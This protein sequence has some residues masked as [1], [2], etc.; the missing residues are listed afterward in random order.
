MSKRTEVLPGTV[1]EHMPSS[2]GTQPK[3]DG[4]EV[5]LTGVRIA[6]G[7]ARGSAWVVGDRLECRGDAHPINPHEVE[8]EWSRIRVAFDQTRAELQ[9]AARRVAE[10]FTAPLADI[11]RAHEMMLDSLLSSPEFSQE[12]QG[13]RVH[14]ETA[15]R[16][17]F[18]RWQEKFRS[19]N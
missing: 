5:T 8:R 10:Q 15:V 9:E 19:L 1:G 17:I 12:L 18:R 6:P 7:L 4:A 3:S 11:F 2:S 16:H 13:S 14:A